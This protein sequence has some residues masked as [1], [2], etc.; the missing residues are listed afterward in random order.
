MRYSEEIQ[1]VCQRNSLEALEVL[2]QKQREI[3]TDYSPPLPDL[4]HAAT[5]W[6]ADKIAAY[7]V[8]NGQ[9]VFDGLMTSV[10]VNNSFAVYRLLVKHKAVDIDY[11][12]PWY[13]D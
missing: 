5:D 13:G 10:V 4:L 2:I 1:A 3:D 11:Y 7:C 9:T 8:E 12:V 6:D